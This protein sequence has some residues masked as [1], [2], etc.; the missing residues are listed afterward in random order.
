MSLRKSG[1][2]VTHHKMRLIGRLFQYGNGPLGLKLADALGVLNRCTVVVKQPW[3]V[4]PQ[5]S[6]VFAH[7][8]KNMLQNLLIDLLIDHLALRKYLLWTMP[9]H[10]KKR[11]QYDFDC[12][13][14]FSLGNIRDFQWQLSYF[15][16]YSKICLIASDD[17]YETSLGQSEDAQ[18]C[19]DT[20]TCNAPFDHHSTVLAPILCWLYTHLNLQ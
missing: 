16:L 7:W 4:L 3:F 2:G 1:G 15:R 14:F 5:L 10:I 18:W 11:I 6:S 8:A 9:P 13:A 12:L 19:P 17:S 20:P